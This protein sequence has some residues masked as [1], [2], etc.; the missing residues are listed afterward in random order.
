MDGATTRGAKRNVRFYHLRNWLGMPLSVWLPLLAENR[1]AVTRIG[2]ATRQTFFSCGNSLFHRLDQLFYS[3]RVA[4]SAEP[5]PPLF[6][7][8]HW[9]TGTT[10]LHELLVQD[11]QFSYPTTFQ[12][13]APH[14][15]LLTERWLPRLL[16]HAVPNRRPMDNMPFGL[17]APQEDEF[18]LCNMGVA[19]PYLRWAFPRHYVEAGWCLDIEALTARERDRWS[20]AMTRFV[21]RLTW[22]DARRLVLKSPTHTARIA[23]LSRL[24]PG[25][26]FVHIVRN[27]Y[28]VFA[29]TMHTWRQLWESM[30]FHSPKFEGL[31]EYVLATLARMYES[32]ERALPNPPSQ[33]LCELRYEDLLL[34]PLGE[35]KKIYDRLEIDGFEDALPNMQT[36]LAKRA[37]YQTNRHELSDDLRGEIRNRWQGYFARYG[38]T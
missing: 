36:L 24:F 28:Q 18:A 34:D 21:R 33:Q 14:H 26:Q 19:S 8:D 7:I 31:E 5:K 1:F 29:S 16:S 11:K 30:G 13:L 10:L 12:V 20:A 15:F 27:P 9:R 23:T 4:A 38:Y 35:L 25:A 37:S 2:Q 3:K 32:F 17:Q 22:R 6:V